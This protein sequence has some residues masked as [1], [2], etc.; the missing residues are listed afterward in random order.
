[1][2]G[3]KVCAT[4]ARH[5]FSTLCI[6]MHA[7]T[8]C[9]YSLVVKDSLRKEVSGKYLI[10]MVCIFPTASNGSQNRRYRLRLLLLLSSHRGRHH[11]PSNVCS[12][13]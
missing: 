1:V 12:H 8:L 6:R 4:T 5:V 9:L 7:G 10:Q 2:L 3:L 11:S 13:C